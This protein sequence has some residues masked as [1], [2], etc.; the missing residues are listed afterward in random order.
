[1][2]V[3]FDGQKFIYLSEVYTMFSPGDLTKMPQCWADFEDL[4][5][6]GVDRVILYGPS[7]TGKTYAGLHYNV[8]PAGAFRLI[9]NEE[10]TSSDVVGHWEPSA[11]STWTWRSGK[12]VRAWEG[13]GTTGGRL[14]A[15]EIHKASG[16]VLS[17]LLA[18]FDTEGSAV[19]EHPETQVV[20]VPRPGFSVVM[21]TNL[22]DIRM[23]PDALLDRFPVRIWVN[24]PHPDSLLNLSPDLR[25]IAANSVCAEPSRRFSLRTFKAFDE[26]R[27]SLGLERSARIIFDDAAPDILDALAIGALLDS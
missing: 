20:H 10:M 18:M 17:L 27:F 1:M 19:W 4:L 2:A 16:D 3:L 22:E 9:C 21:T 25:H 14:V 7:G 6:C 26:I 13:D 24:A 11:S 5:R 8:G 23:L 12:C 15:D